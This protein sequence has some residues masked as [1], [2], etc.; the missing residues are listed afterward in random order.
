MEEV[1]FVEDVQTGNFN[2]IKKLTISSKNLMIFQNTQN[3]ISC[4]KKLQL[5]KHINTLKFVM[6]D[7]EKESAA[8]SLIELI[9]KVKIKTL[10]FEYCNIKICCVYEFGPQNLT[11]Y[12]C[13]IDNRNFLDCV[14]NILESNY[15]LLN[16]EIN[17]VSQ[18]GEIYSKFMMDCIN[19]YLQRNQ[20]IFKHKNDR[21]IYLIC[22]YKY[23]NCIISN[24]PLEIFQNIILLIL[25]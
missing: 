24:L 18:Y 7:F 20:N 2:E 17:N 22:A 19:I 16:F 1:I 15:K 21:L 6:I 5:I 23:S 9:M 13:H 25:G 4:F 10:I 14:Y 3:I 8:I 11:Y 12:N